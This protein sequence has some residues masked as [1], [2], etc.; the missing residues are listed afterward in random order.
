MTMTTIPSIS[1]KRRRA[2]VREAVYDHDYHPFPFPEEEESFS[3]DPS[4]L[5]LRKV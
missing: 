3:K 5:P 1:K 2:F 4:T